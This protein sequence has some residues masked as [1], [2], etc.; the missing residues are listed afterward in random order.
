[1]TGKLFLKD[2]ASDKS[3]RFN[4]RI[5]RESTGSVI[6]GIFKKW[7]IILPVILG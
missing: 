2:R 7:E 6:V 5:E 4:R 3:Q 1:M